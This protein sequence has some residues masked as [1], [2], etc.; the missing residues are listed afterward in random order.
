M[1]LDSSG[2]TLQKISGEQDTGDVV[3]KGPLVVAGRQVSGVVLGLVMNV[4][5]VLVVGA[6][7]VVVSMVVVR[8]VVLGV[9]VVVV[10]GA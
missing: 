3:V 5:G 4:V 6:P 8:K 9:V 1:K 7:V 2:A 10:V